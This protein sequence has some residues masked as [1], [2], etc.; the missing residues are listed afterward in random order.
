MKEI[1]IIC[2]NRGGC[3][4]TRLMVAETIFH[5]RKNQKTVTFDW[6]LNNPDF[7]AIMHFFNKDHTEI[8]NRI[9]S[10]EVFVDNTKKRLKIF[11]PMN[12]HQLQDDEFWK[13]LKGVLDST[14]RDTILIVDT[15]VDITRLPCWNGE[16]VK[17]MER[18]KDIKIT[19]YYIWGWVYR[20]DEL[21]LIKQ[22]Y[23]WLRK[24][25]PNVNFVHVWNVNEQKNPKKLFK[26]IYKKY[27][28]LL[29]K[30]TKRRISIRTLLELIESLN[31]SHDTDEVDAND[32][33]EAIWEECFEKMIDMVSGKH[34]IYNWLLIPE[35]I[36]MSF[37]TDADI[38]GNRSDIRLLE[39]NM[40][41]FYKYVY[42]FEKMRDKLA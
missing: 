30:S 18:F 17:Y 35:K 34:A 25:L 5:I 3:G 27:K 1:K 36:D 2:G 33:P 10:T 37:S 7:L 41:K 23:G 8:D 9:I 20:Y 14:R 22:S 26:S 16:C 12:A 42:D 40:K 29:L 24:Y 6:N 28:K 21:D 19:I 31:F 39:S 32:I 15:R 38:A 13:Y 4:K 11:Y